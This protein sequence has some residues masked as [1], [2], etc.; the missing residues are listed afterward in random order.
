MSGARRVGAVVLCRFGSRRLPGKILRE[1]GGASVLEHVVR[2]VRRSVIDD[3]IV[4]ATTTAAE[5]DPIATAAGELGVAVF[6]GPAD[7]VALRFLC[8]AVE[9]RLD[10]AIRVNGDNLFGCRALLDHSVALA[11]R[12]EWDLVTNVPGR[13]W[14]RGMSVEAVDVPFYRSHVGQMW[15]PEHA[16]H[17]TSWLYDND[18]V[19]RRLVLRN[20]VHPELHGLQL[21]I[22]TPADLARAARM[23]SAFDVDPADADLAAVERAWRRATSGSPA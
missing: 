23:W 1:I 10:V 8:A 21:A 17:V 9:R 12:R 4:V 22:D 16:E 11:H 18:D 15:R 5:D 13:T 2:R 19:G 14:P 3:A 6:R 7:D 20:D